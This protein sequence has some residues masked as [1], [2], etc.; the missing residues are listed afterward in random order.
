M[1]TLR[2]KIY[3]TIVGLSTISGTVYGAFNYNDIWHDDSKF[4]GYCCGGIFGAY[5]GFAYGILFPISVPLSI[6][7]T[8]KKKHK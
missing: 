7:H 4:V 6:Y 1:N 5:A 3:P 2:N 8:H